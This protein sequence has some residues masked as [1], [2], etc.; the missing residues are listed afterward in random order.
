[1]P[2]RAVDFESTASANSAKRPSISFLIRIAV[3]IGFRRTYGRLRARLVRADFAN[4]RQ[5][6]RVRRTRID[7]RILADSFRP[8]VG[9]GHN[10]RNRIRQ[11]RQSGNC[12]RHA[13][14]VAM[15]VTRR[16]RM[17]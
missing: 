8:A 5:C 15:K 12:R 11:I 7:T 10:G 6:G 9:A 16:G 4:G 13:L 2:L 17:K 1:M 14:A 3:F